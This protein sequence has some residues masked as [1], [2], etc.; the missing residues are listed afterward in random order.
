M[1]T[2]LLCGG[3]FNIIL[4]ILYIQF[5]FFFFFFLL[6]KFI[7][8]LVRI[9]N[10]SCCNEV[11]WE[12][13]WTNTVK[14]Y[15]SLIQNPKWV[16]LDIRQPFHVIIRGP[17]P[18]CLTSP[19][20]LRPQGSLIEPINLV[21]SGGNGEAWRIRILWEVFMVQAWSTMSL[22]PTFHW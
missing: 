18:L 16:L 14:F 10:T 6:F 7:V 17:R 3:N 21:H 1:L 19:L 8:V 5:V 13:W 4:S 2:F 15:L 9:N 22:L 20:F 11:I 12:S